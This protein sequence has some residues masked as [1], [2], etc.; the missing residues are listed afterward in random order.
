L[1]IPSGWNA[2][3]SAF[4]P[5]S[6][7]RRIKRYAATAAITMAI[8]ATPTATPIPAFAPVDKP[9]LFCVAA[10][11]VCGCDCDDEAVGIE[12]AAVGEEVVAA[13][14]VVLDDDFRSE[15]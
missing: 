10:K 6:L 5:G 4:G 3:G 1:L 12:E 11:L 9:V 8:P 15:A 14:V 7:L 13:E 2:V